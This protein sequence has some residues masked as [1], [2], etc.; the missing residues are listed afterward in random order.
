MS[1]LRIH[2]GDIVRASGREPKK[3][4]ERIRDNL[5]DKAYDILR[6]YTGYSGTYVDF[7]VGI[8]LCRKYLL[9]KLVEQFHILKASLKRPVSGVESSQERPSSS[10]ITTPLAIGTR[11]E[12]V[13]AQRSSIDP[14]EIWNEAETPTSARKGRNSQAEHPQTQRDVS[15]QTQRLLPPHQPDNNAQNVFHDDSHPIS[16]RTGSHYSIWASEPHSHLSEVKPDLKPYS[17]ASR[18]SYGGFSDTGYS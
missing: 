8:N 18:S 3:T 5:P 11:L 12:S 9:N 4:V 17:W 2:A 10:Q 13:L 6:G 7:Q 1:D 15:L 14:G 16:P